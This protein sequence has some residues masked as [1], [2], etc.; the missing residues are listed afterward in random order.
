M[1]E[2]IYLNHRRSI[3]IFGKTLIV[4]SE[5]GT[6]E[7]ER[8]RRPGFLPHA[9]VLFLPLNDEENLLNVRMRQWENGSSTLTTSRCC[10]SSSSARSSAFFFLPLSQARVAPFERVLLRGLFLSLITRI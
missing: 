5:K 7:G 3:Y 6:G 9:F 1:D 8:E 10:S 2:Y 4:E